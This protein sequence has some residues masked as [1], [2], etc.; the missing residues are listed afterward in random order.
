[1][2]A[3]QNAKVSPIR[4]AHFVLVTSRFEQMKRWYLTVLQAHVQF[5]NEQLAFLTYDEEHHRIALAN[6][7]GL[8]DKSSKHAGLHHA[9]FTYGSIGDLLHTYKRL[10]AEAIAPHWCVNHGPTTS[11]YYHDPDRNSVELQIDNFASTEALNGWFKSGAF[12]RNPIGVKFDPDALVLRYE[13][14]EPLEQL[15]KQSSDAAAEVPL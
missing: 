4:L 6:V 11:M 12:E 8:E 1:M 7:P 15:V 13:R 9:A 14:G 5:E 3:S 2:E 10:K